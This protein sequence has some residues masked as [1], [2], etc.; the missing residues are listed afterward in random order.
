LWI[1][2]IVFCKPESKS[3][4]LQVTDLLTTVSVNS[5]YQLSNILFTSIHTTWQSLTSNCAKQ[6]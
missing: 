3:T 2:I 5:H 4:Q 1:F 6:L